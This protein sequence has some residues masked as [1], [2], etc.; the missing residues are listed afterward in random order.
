MNGRKSIMLIRCV[1]SADGR[2][3]MN[4]KRGGESMELGK[5]LGMLLVVAVVMA[6][7]FLANMRKVKRAMD[8]FEY[9]WFFVT[10]LIYTFI[11]WIA[12]MLIWFGIHMITG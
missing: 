10:Y 3:G 4:W 2:S 8:D 1:S 11:I 7:Y 12:G 6:V 5:A 9:R